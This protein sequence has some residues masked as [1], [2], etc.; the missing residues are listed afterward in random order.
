MYLNPKFHFNQVQLRRST[1]TIT[2]IFPKELK[3]ILLSGLQLSVE[4]N[5]LEMVP[6]LGRQE[7]GRTQKLQMRLSERIQKRQFSQMERHN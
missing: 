6:A 7:L 5:R 3:V 4:I 2:I 1:N